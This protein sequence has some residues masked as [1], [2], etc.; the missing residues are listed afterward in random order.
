MN[1]NGPRTCGCGRADSAT[2]ASSRSAYAVQPPSQLSHTVR[3]TRTGG[4]HHA[5]GADGG[6][7]CGG[8]PV[9]EV[10]R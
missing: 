4:G 1:S 9:D 5:P 6:A 2:G 8:S 10:W 7:V 3:T